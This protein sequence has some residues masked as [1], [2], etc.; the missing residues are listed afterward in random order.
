MKEYDFILKFDLPDHDADP[1]Q[2]VDDLYASG[3]DD[4]NV[5]I[6]VTGRIALNFIREA[7]SAND[8]V[9][10]AIN[11]VQKAIP[12]AR[13]IEATPDLVG[14]TDIAEIIGCSRQNMRKIIV[15]H[16]AAFP[17]PVHEGSAVIWHLSKVLKW[18]K[19]NGNYEIDDSLLEVSSINM[20]VNVTAQFKEI[21][22]A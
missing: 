9:T 10:S 2:Y 13:L 6:G 1:E 21:Q 12:G 15:T 22:T 8:A 19:S 4:A 7:P 3:C 17:S 20:K 18:L 16:K 5:G 14:I 11:D